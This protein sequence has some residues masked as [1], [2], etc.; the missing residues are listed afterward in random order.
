MKANASTPGWN[1][2][3]DKI[4]CR[5]CLER[6]L[7]CAATQ[8]IH[9]NSKEKKRNIQDPAIWCWAAHLILH[10]ITM[11]SSLFSWSSKVK[12]DVKVMNYTSNRKLVALKAWKPWPSQTWMRSVRLMCQKS[13][14]KILK[15]ILVIWPAVSSNSVTQVFYFVAKTIN[16]TVRLI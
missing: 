10:L 5:L 3:N 12:P 11:L 9:V 13:F 4:S 14:A 1:Q 8:S 16:S 15:Q 2:M 7:H 6:L